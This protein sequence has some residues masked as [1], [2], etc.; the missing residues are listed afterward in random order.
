MP[1]FPPLWKSSRQSDSF[2]DA[3]CRFG[4]LGD[5]C[6][7]AECSRCVVKYVNEEEEKLMEESAWENNHG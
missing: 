1:G 6:D 4:D 5:V 3:T 7:C 2:D